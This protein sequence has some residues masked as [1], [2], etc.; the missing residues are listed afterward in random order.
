MYSVI[1][2]QF[3]PALT[4]GFSVIT[5]LVFFFLLFVLFQLPV[6]IWQVFPVSL[7][8]SKLL[9]LPRPHLVF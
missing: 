2:T 6:P 7:G 9:L 3:S 1:C 5:N 8:H 4:F